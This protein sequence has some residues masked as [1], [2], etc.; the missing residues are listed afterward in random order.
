M[1]ESLIVR[2]III[3]LVAGFVVYMLICACAE[4]MGAAMKEEED[5]DKRG[6]E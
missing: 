4:L 5:D 6:G 1:I 3:C 2:G